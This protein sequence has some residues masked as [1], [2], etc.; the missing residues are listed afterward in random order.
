[1]DAVRIHV[2]SE[3][4][5]P[6]ESSH[7]EGT[8]DLPVMKAGP[9]LHSFSEPLAWQV[10]VTNTGDA[11]LV[12][13]TVEGEATT[14]CARCLDEFSFPVTGEI[15]GYY[16]IGSETEAPQDMDADEFDVL[17]DDNTIDLEPLI[18][19]ALM[20]HVRRQPERG[21]LR[22][23]A[24]LRRGDGGRSPAQSVLGPEGLSVRREVSEG[25][26]ETAR[27]FMSGALRCWFPPAS[28]LSGPGFHLHP[29]SRPGLSLSLSL[30]TFLLALPTMSVSYLSS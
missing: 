14:S 10:D 3:L 11:F 19:A 30:L 20:P 5:A 22:L 16:L 8:F 26:P 7:F 29:A 21:S 27:L 13:G 25:G 24:G 2:P 4:F 17:P 15:E 6:A 18:K 1:M 9:D 12:A 23:R 28:R